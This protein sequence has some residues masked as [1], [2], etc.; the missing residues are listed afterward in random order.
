MNL[1]GNALICDKRIEK[2]WKGETKAMNSNR[3]AWVNWYK[4]ILLSVC[5]HLLLG[6]IDFPGYCCMCQYSAPQ[7]GRVR[8]NICGNK[9]A[10]WF[11]YSPYIRRNLLD[12]WMIT[13]LPRT[14]PQTPLRQRR[15]DPCLQFP[16][17]TDYRADTN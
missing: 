10:I 15:V 3:I 13:A 4:V 9:L 14:V 7:I 6:E 12:I 2:M 8:C 1:Q 11:M 17:N 5:S 16:V